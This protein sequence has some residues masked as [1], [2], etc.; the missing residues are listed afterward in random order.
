[1]KRLILVLSL[2]LSV[3]IASGQHHHAHNRHSDRQEYRIRD[4]HR[5][6]GFEDRRVDV[7]CVRDHQ[8]LWNG[9]HVKVNHFGVSVLDRR[10]H[11]I[12][13]GEEVILL[14][15]GDYKVY[16]GGFWRVYTEHGDRLQNVW[17]DSVDLMHNGL[18]RCV[19]AG[20]VHYY[21]LNGHEHRDH[22]RF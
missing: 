7:L 1:M 20:N 6:R 21:D 22:H 8:E 14:A 13:K 11:K 5:H 12:V 15:S 18:F 3:F 16:N 10:N 17:G 19:R 2:L 9:C 4:H